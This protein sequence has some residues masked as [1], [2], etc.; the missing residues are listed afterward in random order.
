[1]KNKHSILLLDTC[2]SLCVTLFL[3]IQ[4]NKLL[5]YDIL[6]LLIGVVFYILFYKYVRYDSNK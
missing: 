1:M 2:F 4:L 3:M 6:V 5:N